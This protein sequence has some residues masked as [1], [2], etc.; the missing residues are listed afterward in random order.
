MSYLLVSCNWLGGGDQVVPTP[1]FVRAEVSNPSVEYSGS[2][3][4]YWEVKY[5]NYIEVDGTKI[6]LLKGSMDFK[7]LTSDKVIKIV[8]YG[9]G[10]LES[11]KTITIHVLSA[12]IVT[13]IDTICS[14]PLMFE[15]KLYTS[16]DNGSTWSTSDLDVSYDM[17]VFTKDMKLSLYKSPYTSTDTKGPGDWSIDLKQRVMYFGGNGAKK[18]TLTDKGM[19]VIFDNEYIDEKGV[20]HP[21]LMKNIFTFKN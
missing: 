9:D 16:I 15:H 4:L 2:T 7:N 11:S 13:A 19:I 20:H 1:E 12:P 10:S 3:T 14:K 6:D 5:A 18:F 17:Y 8:A 21:A